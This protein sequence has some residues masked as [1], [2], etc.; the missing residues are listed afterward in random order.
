MVVE[1]EGELEG[2]YGFF[3]I[4]DI[5]IRIEVGVLIIEIFRGMLMIFWWV[6]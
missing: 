5:G 3:L 1:I 2:Y 6:F 4:V